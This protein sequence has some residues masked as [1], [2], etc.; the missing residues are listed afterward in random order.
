MW[1]GWDWLMVFLFVCFFVLIYWLQSQSIY[2]DSF[3]LSKWKHTS[4]K[5]WKNSFFMH[6]GSYCFGF[7]EAK[8]CSFSPPPS[9]PPLDGHKNN[10]F[11]GRLFWNSQPPGL[12]ISKLGRINRSNTSKQ[13]RQTTLCSSSW[14]RWFPLPLHGWVQIPGNTI[15]NLKQVNILNSHSIF[16]IS[17]G[18]LMLIAFIALFMF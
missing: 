5:A 4:L 6:N 15:K 9:A 7:S 16:C 3:T 10:C 2:K 12:P 17:S 11:L 14:I 18:K 13:E 1:Q 8:M